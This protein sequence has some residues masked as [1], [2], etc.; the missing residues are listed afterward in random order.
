L[1]REVESLFHELADLPPDQREK[2]LQSRHVSDEV[3]AEVE[4]LLRFDSG[5]ED[6]SLTEHV[7]S[8]AQRSL[9][10][11]LDP[12]SRCG[13]YRLL[14]VLGRGG[15]G[16]VYLAERADGEVE[17]RVAIKIIGPR[18]FEPAFIGRFLRERQILAT[19][20]HPGIAR[21]LDVGHTG[22]GQP[23]LAMEYIDGAPIDAYAAKLD[24]RGKLT[25]FLKACEAVS[26]AHRNLIIHRDIKPSN[27]L[28]ESSGELK[29]LDFGIA[30][31]LDAT[32]DQTLTQERILTPAFAS[33]EQVRGT[34]QA[35]TSDIYSLG[36]V[37]YQLL[38]G[39][40][41]HTFSTQSPQ[42]IELA[43]CLTEPA[44]P[45]RVNAAIPKDLD[46]IVLK[47][48]RKE[49]EERYGSADALADDIRAFL[50]SRPVRARR[51]NAWY[52]SRKFLRRH[53]L[54]MAAAAAIV[55]SLAAGLFIANRERAIAQRH[56][57]EVRQLANKLFD[58][59][60]L[61][62]QLPGSTKTRQLIV[63]TSLE[64]LG[65]LAADAH[66][67]PGLALEV[68]NAYMWVAR[69]QG[70]P[71]ASNLGQVDQA[72]KNLRL[73]DGFIHSVL[74]AQPGNR[75]ALLRSA[76]VARD[77]MILADINGRSGEANEFARQAVAGLEKFNAQRNDRSEAAAI[78]SV[79]LN[80]AQVYEHVQRADEALALCRR[81]SELAV[82]FGR[83]PYRGAF[84]QVAARISQGRGDLDEALRSIR[85]SA[86][87]LEPGPGSA[88]QAQT[89][90]YVMSLVYEGEILGGANAI[91]MG[92]NEEAIAVLSRAFQI[93][94]ERV[95]QD[96]N[97][98][99][100]RGRLEMAG[101]PLASVLRESDP[102]LALSVYDHTLRH[103]AEIKTNPN[104]QFYQARAM[105]GSSYPLRELGRAAEARQR[106]DSAFQ[107]LR[108]LNMYPADEIGLGSGAH[109]VLTAQADYEAATGNVARALQIYQELLDR[110][111]RAKPGPENSLEDAMDQS[112]IY[113][114]MAAVHRR[115]GHASLA[116]ALNARRLELWRLW[117]KKLPGNMYVLRQIALAASH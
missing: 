2:Y 37:L 8:S 109:R 112:G 105:A 21:L 17:Q 82:V 106:L 54:P 97:D 46:F 76:E 83:A 41:P 73:A 35:T 15:M 29:L 95:H 113:T 24:L 25:L 74:A 51:G 92:R 115:A 58:I 13:P 72:D 85:E 6:G 98:E 16:S 19:L 23:Y 38:T 52:A 30:K 94:D 116:A 80:V 18:R 100:T 93:A 28:V 49:P 27:I 42:A 81:G 3:R 4:G 62:R 10:E 32:M 99:N 102:R 1:K 26:Y 70:V 84:L 67:D 79:Y 7:A 31:M 45:S 34:A 36:A 9:L 103:L 55:C 68:G 108:Q 11:S 90:N 56:F 14:R 33:P 65:R 117:E 88:D 91:S 22:D 114:G 71:L 78:L 57:L 101:Y 96:P 5:A 107:L 111:S 77:R 44:P 47:A 48:L 43:V 86:A 53:W 50:E 89:M 69:V 104:V 12:N 75:M 40:S 64:Y 87:A 39:Q 59:D 20:S 66:G 63:D 61:A 110:T 60:A